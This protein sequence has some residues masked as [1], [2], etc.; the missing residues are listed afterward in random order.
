VYVSSWSCARARVNGEQRGGAAGRAHRETQQQA[1][2]ADAAVANELRRG[3][4]VSALV[5]ADASTAAADA[6]AA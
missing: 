1:R 2:F 4:R 5:L 6:P 3:A